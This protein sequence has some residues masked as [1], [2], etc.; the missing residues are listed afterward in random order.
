MITE[1]PWERAKEMFLTPDRNMTY[2]MKAADIWLG[3]GIYGN[4]GYFSQQYFDC[5]TIG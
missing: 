1:V 5:L 2:Y 4:R 3:W